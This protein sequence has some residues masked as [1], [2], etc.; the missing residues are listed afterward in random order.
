[1]IAEETEPDV[2]LFTT[3]FGSAPIPSEAFGHDQYDPLDRSEI[4]GLA[5]C[6][7]CASKSPPE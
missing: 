1:M 6:S 3:R 2:W 4:S 5:A 7:L